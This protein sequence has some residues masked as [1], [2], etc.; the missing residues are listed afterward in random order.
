MDLRISEVVRKYVCVVKRSM[1]VRKIGDEAG[2]VFYRLK[3][4]IRSV[5]TFSNDQ[6]QIKSE[7]IVHE[8]ARELDVKNR[9]DADIV[10]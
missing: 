4:I 1:S 8:G 7:V 10:V 2:V 6:G 3:C 9:V 5:V